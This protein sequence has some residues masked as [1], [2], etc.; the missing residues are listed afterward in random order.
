M[1]SNEFASEMIFLSPWRRKDKEGGTQRV[2]VYR[3]MYMAVVVG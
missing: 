3:H 1:M 2:P